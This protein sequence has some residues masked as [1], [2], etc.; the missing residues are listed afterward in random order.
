MA[1]TNLSLADFKTTQLDVAKVEREVSEANI[2]YTINWQLSRSRL[3]TAKVKEMSE[4]SGTTAKPFRQKGTGN[5][6]QGSRRSV[7]MRGGR[8]CFGPTPRSFDFALPKKISK[9]A[10][11]DAL[12]IKINE[13]KVV[14][15][16]NVEKCAI[17]TAAFNKFLNDNKINSALIVHSDDE[18]KNKNLIKSARNIKNVKVLNVAGLNTYDLLRYQFLIIE[19]KLFENLKKGL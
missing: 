12:S 17:K 10:T 3:G 2:A 9:K 16:N 14:L 19:D 5:A 13:E 7:Q 15:L 4:I 11:A 8:T 18:E 6:R 1:V